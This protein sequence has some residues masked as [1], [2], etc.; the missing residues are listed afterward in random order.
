M[1]LGEVA[2]KG[3]CVVASKTPPHASACDECA[4]ERGECGEEENGYQAYGACVGSRC[5]S[6]DLGRWEEADVAGVDSVE[7]LD[8]VEEGDQVDK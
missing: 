7:V 6:V 8:G 3:C 2:R 1:D 5:L 4:D